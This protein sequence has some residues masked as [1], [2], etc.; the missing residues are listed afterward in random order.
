MALWS[1]G[2]FEKRSWPG[3]LLPIRGGGQEGQD[4]RIGHAGGLGDVVGFFLGNGA[5]YGDRS[6]ERWVR[7]MGQSR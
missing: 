6:G 3:T 7:G 2:S 5:G 1:W 4:L